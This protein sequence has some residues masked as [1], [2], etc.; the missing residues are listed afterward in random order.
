[1][2]AIEGTGL[3]RQKPV[4]E[5]PTGVQHGQANNTNTTSH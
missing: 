5:V 1:M 4:K 3:F 2:F